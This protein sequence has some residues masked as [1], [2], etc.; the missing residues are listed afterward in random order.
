MVRVIT[1]IKGLRKSSLFFRSVEH[2]KGAK[3]KNLKI[4]C[5]ALFLFF[6]ISIQSCASN[7]GQTNPEEGAYVFLLHGF[8]RTNRS[9][10]KLENHISDSGYSV[11]NVNYPST[12]YPIEYLA[13][14]I[15]NDAIQRNIKNSVSKIHFV[16][17]SMGGIVVRYYLKY[18]ELPNLGRVVMLSPPN[19]GTE[20]VDFFKD[21]FFFKIFDWPAGR[22]LGT[23]EDSIP[24]NLGPVDFELGIITGN[25][26]FNPFYSTILSGPDDGIVTVERAKVEGMSDFIVLPHSHTFIILNDEVIEQVIHFL[27]HGRFRHDG[28]DANEAPRY[29]GH[30]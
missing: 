29:E 5:L 20:L 28:P 23:D 22:Q 30:G 25:K 10:D 2:P 16:T 17:H 9:M 24:I 14:E 1:V 15:L 13:D 8:G 4:A 27:E 3:H 7:E 19:Q 6:L 11:I 26:S 21:S 18:H 12:K